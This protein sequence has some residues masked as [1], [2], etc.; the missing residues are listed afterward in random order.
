LFTLRVL[1]ESEYGFGLK[2]V[3][4]ALHPAFRI[5]K[6]KEKPTSFALLPYAQTTCG[7]L[8]ITLTKHIRS[9]CL[10]PRKISTFLSPLKDNLGLRTPVVYSIPCES[11]QVNI[12]QTRRSVETRI[13]K[14]H[15]FIW[16]GHPD[17]SAVAEHTFNRH[18]LIKSLNTQILY[19]IS[20]IEIR[21]AIEFTST[22]TLSTERMA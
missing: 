14:H 7:G 2:Q 17:K 10:T 12:R 22:Q 21:E 9:V 4:R 6:L 15:H 3:R 1:Y 11:G 20:G 18:H 16:L 19:Y 5:S 13:K 8:S